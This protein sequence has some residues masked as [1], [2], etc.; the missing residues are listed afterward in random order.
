VDEFSKKFEQEFLLVSHLSSGTIS[1]GAWLL[2]SGATCH[3]TGARELFESFTELDSDV[4]MELGMG[5][6]HAVKGS[7]IVPYQMES[8]GVMRVMDMLWVP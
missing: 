4:Y 6:K 8:V 5:T 2:D 7:G 3:M 1:V